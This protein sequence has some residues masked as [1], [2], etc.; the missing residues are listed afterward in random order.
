M[1]PRGG[2]ANLTDSELRSAILYMY[3]PGGM[4]VSP[5]ASTGTTVVNQ[6]ANHRTVNGTDVYLGIVSAENIR[7]LP[8]GSPERSMH[9][10]VPRGAGYFHVNISLF[11]AKTKAPINQALVKMQLT[12]EGVAGETITLEPMLGGKE[13]SYGNY[14]KPPPGGP[15]QLT[16]TIKPPGGKKVVRVKFESEFE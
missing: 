5:T 4:P 9:G 6:D 8:K 13:G 10:G 7:A 2:Q 14:I 11:D 16:F 3:N 15:Y 1:P 12:H